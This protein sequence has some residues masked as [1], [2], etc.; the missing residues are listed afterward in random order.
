MTHVGVA[1]GLVCTG[2]G[3]LGLLVKV[4]AAGTERYILSC[5]HV[6]ARGGS[7]SLPFPKLFDSEKVV[8]QPAP[9]PCL[10]GVNEIGLLTDSP[11][12]FSVLKK[13]TRTAF[14]CALV[15]LT[16]AVAGSVTSVQQLTQS[17]VTVLAREHPSS[18]KGMT[19]RL[20][21]AKRLDQRDALGKVVGLE[22]VVDVTFDGIGVVPVE[23]AVVY[24]TRCAKGDSGGAVIDEQNRLLGMHIAGRADGLQGVFLPLGEFFKKYDLHLVE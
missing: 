9:E 12:P 6:V 17:K 15:R 8:Q 18:F 24:N 4:G 1:G 21:G 11:A 23:N 13:N 7:F 20:L 22:S 16:S 5:S 14:D 19:T 2:N 3:T 10:R